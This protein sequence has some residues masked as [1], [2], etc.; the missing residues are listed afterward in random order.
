[1]AKFRMFRTLLLS[2]YKKLCPEAML[3]G[4]IVVYV[5]EFSDLLRNSLIRF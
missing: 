2:S 5:T 1:M 4:I 3:R